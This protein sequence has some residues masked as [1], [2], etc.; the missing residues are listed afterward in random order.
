MDEI[1]KKKQTICSSFVLKYRS[2][3]FFL[4]TT[5]FFLNITCFV[6]GPVVGFGTLKYEFIYIY[7]LKKHV[8]IRGITIYVHICN[9]FLLQ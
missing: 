4:A 5:V 6:F 9:Y 8:Y 1:K 7:G 2:V 3:L